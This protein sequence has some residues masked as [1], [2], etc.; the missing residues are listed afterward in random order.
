MRGGPDAVETLRGFGIDVPKTTGPK[1][2]KSKAAAAAQGQATRAKHKEALASVD[3][4][5]PSVSAQGAAPGAANV[6][7]PKS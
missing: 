6:T 4:A 7:P 2:A 5:P 1:S 3:A